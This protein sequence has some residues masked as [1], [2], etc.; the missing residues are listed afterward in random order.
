[1]G[2]GRGLVL[3]MGLVMSMASYAERLPVDD[4]I[5]G[6]RAKANHLEKMKTLLQKNKCV[7]NFGPHKY[8][9]TA[10]AMAD[11]AL[12]VAITDSI[13]GATL[14]YS[15]APKPQLL[16]NIVQYTHR[17]AV[18]RVFILSAS[19]IARPGA[20]DYTHLK[21]TLAEPMQ[22]KEMENGFMYDKVEG[23]ISLDSIEKGVQT[24]ELTMKNGGSLSVTCN[25]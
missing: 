20:E 15:A 16:K 10:N 17:Q 14:S 19:L 11:N 7:A 4:A 25:K 8:P 1:M 6:L 12:I 18:N 5:D 22:V 23:A 24:R 3:G 2:M 9:L 21:V 13:P